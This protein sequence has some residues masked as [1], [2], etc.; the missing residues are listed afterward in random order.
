MGVPGKQWRAHSNPASMRTDSFAFCLQAHLVMKAQLC[1]RRAKEFC[2]VSAEFAK[3]WAWSKRI[4]N[5]WEHG[6]CISLLPWLWSS[7][8][9]YGN[10][11]WSYLPLDKPPAPA[12]HT[13]KQNRGAQVSC[14]QL[15]STKCWLQTIISVLDFSNLR[16]MLRGESEDEIGKASFQ[17]SE[18]RQRIWCVL[19][20]VPGAL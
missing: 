18:S 17:S 10:A 5:I 9:E 13:G 3:R 15:L 20:T 8:A 2:F 11:D 4:R 12:I 14:W 7:A 19:I 16:C 1:D 6:F